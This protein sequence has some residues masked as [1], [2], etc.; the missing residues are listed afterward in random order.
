MIKQYTRLKVA[1]NTGAVELQVITVRGFSKKSFGAIG[2]IVSASVKKALPNS[3]TKKGK[4]VRAI[5]VRQNKEWRRPDGTY[6]RFDD[7]AAVILDDELKNVK[8]T[9]IFGP[10]PREIKNTKF[11]KIISLAKEII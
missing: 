11:S 8:G 6:V 3:Q 1:D 4:V 2:D 5:I 10:I 9:R 7:N